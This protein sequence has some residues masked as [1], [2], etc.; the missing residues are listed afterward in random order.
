MNRLSAAA[1]CLLLASGCGD[2]NGKDTKDSKGAAGKD[3]VFVSGALFIAGDGTPPVEGA[4]MIIED[5]V[6]TKI[7]KKGRTLCSKGFVA[8]R[9]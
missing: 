1:L 9:S 6:I 4:T 8:S 2:S 7:G 3:V 5:G